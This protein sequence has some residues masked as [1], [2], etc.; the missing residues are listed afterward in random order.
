MPIK[1]I[2]TEYDGVIYRSRT[3]A[4]WAF[5]F[6]K[7]DIPFSYEAEGFD[8]DGIRYLP[9]FWLNDARI[10]FEVKPFSPT[11]AEIEKA[12][13]LSDG[14]NR[15]VFIAPGAPSSSI[16]LIGV[17]Q[18]SLVFEDFVFGYAHGEGVGYI[19][20]DLWGP[21]ILIKLSNAIT[22][23]LDC[24]CGY[25]PAAELEAAGRHQFDWRRPVV[26]T[27]ARYVSRASEGRIAVR[28]RTGPVIIRG[29]Q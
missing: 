18:D 27:G 10:W 7:N 14:T 19:V 17:F 25:G 28:E 15:P 22:A 20:D 5:F 29:V 6:S 1:S 12:K 4:R 23:Y 3:E 21:A 11:D 8:L 24:C 26:D 16:R 13:R 2:A 9:D